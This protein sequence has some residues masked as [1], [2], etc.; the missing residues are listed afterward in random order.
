MRAGSDCTGAAFGTSPGAGALEVEFPAGAATVFSVQ[1]SDS[2]GNQSCASAAS[3]WVNDPSLP[4]DHVVLVPTQ[5]DL[6]QMFATPDCSGY[7]FQTG[8][9]VT[10][11]TFGVDLSYFPGAS[12]V[13]VRGVRNDGGVETCSN[14]TPL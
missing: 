12:F 4:E 2:A 6:V 3:P 1:A 7:A 14:A 13:S 10:F 9:A 5:R 8:A 11:I